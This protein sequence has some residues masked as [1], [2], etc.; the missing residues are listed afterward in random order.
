MHL[1]RFS[2]PLALA[3]G[4]V[5]ATTAHASDHLDAP[6]LMGNGQVDV[7]DLYAFQSPTNPANTVLILTVNPGAGVLSPRT[8]GTDVTYSFKI[9]NTGDAVADISYDATFGAP[10]AG[11]QA[12]TLMGPGGVIAAGSTG[13]T[14]PTT[15]GG[16]VQAGVYDDPFFFDLNGFNDGLN[17][18]GDDF[19]AGL[20]T[21][22]IILELP[23]SLLGGPNL[24]IWAT[25]TQGGSQVDRVGRPAINTVLIPSAR[26][27]EFNEASPA[28][29]FS[30]FGTDVNSAIAGLSTQSNADAL[31]PV[32]LPD[33][34]TFD[35]SSAAGFLNGRQLADD[36]ID[37]ELTLLTASSTPIGDGVDANDKAFLGSFPY[38]AAANI[39]EPTTIAIALIAV[40]GLATGRRRA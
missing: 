29:D 22:A 37:A 2:A 8:F 30:A 10:V 17:F 35:T 7:N 33:V 24:G 23:S 40:S 3:V 34:L 32:L 26:K 18:T 36:V 14:A 9:D 12:L 11:V 27:Q 31:T 21:S 39:P 16:M 20:D 4:A 1:F 38:L 6:N 13:A 19:F 5:V 15:G 28:N 25:T